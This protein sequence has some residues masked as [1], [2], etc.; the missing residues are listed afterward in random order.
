ME[1]AY[2]KQR[3]YVLDFGNY[4]NCFANPADYWLK[5]IVQ[6][7]TRKEPNMKVREVILKY[8]KLVPFPWTPAKIKK[9]GFNPTELLLQVGRE[10]AECEDKDTPTAQALL[11]TLK[12]LGM[13]S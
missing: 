2:F 8:H 9:A 13:L 10:L 6:N 4:H 7:L 3:R 5:V 12:D 1:W 11:D